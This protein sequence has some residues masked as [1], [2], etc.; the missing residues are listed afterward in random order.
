M[1]NLSL[2]FLIWTLKVNSFIQH[3]KQGISKAG[4]GGHISLPPHHQYRVLVV[5][6]AGKKEPT[7][8][9]Y[10]WKKLQALHNEFLKSVSR[11]V[12]G[13]YF[14][15]YPPPGGNSLLNVLREKKRKNGMRGGG[16][17]LFLGEIC[18]PPTCRF[19]YRFHLRREAKTRLY[20]YRH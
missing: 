18:T 17:N 3:K 11:P 1:E 7:I 16:H 4:G 5:G 6:R 15:I 19:R 14:F 2:N 13:V 12:A 9:I 10:R 20:I 8:Q